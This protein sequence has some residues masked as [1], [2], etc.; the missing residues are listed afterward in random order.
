MSHNVKVE[1]KTELITVF[2][3][4][5]RDARV[6][7]QK[8]GDNVKF[9]S[10]TC[11]PGLWRMLA[12]ILPFNQ[13]TDWFLAWARQPWRKKHR[14]NHSSYHLHI[15]KVA[16][17]G[18]QLHA[19]LPRTTFFFFSSSTSTVIRIS[20]EATLLL[21]LI[22]TSSYTDMHIHTSNQRLTQPVH[23]T[24]KW[25]GLLLPHS[26][27]QWHLCTTHEFSS[28]FSILNIPW[29]SSVLL[30]IKSWVIPM[31]VQTHAFRWISVPPFL[32][33]V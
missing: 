6:R 5:E 10:I 31:F 15:A 8:E 30:S 26:H 19:D 27:S 17:L 11:F 2:S 9:S 24:L 20:R 22:N 16:G 23:I 28:N 1:S 29:N 25:L 12:K 7:E 21:L 18:S 14:P 4:L 13:K 3:F 33:L 32:F